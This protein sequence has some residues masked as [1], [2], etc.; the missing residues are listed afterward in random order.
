MFQGKYRRSKNL[1]VFF[2]SEGGWDTASYPKY[3]FE[4][5]RGAF[6]RRKEILLAVAQKM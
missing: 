2:Y 1:I 3:N 4:L 6:K 5:Y